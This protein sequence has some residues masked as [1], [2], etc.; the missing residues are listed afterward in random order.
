MRQ[1]R[2]HVNAHLLEYINDRLSANSIQVNW[3]DTHTGFKIQVQF[4]I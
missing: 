3:N 1:A 4:L 2:E